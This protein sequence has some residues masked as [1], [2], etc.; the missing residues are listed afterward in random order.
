[1]NNV[2]SSNVLFPVNDNTSTAHVAPSSNHGYVARV[3]LDKVGD[4]ILFKVEL[5]CV[6]DTDQGIRITD[7]ATV[8]GDNVRNT[9]IAYSNAA[10]FEE[11]IF[12]FLGCDAVDG[13]S[14]LDIVKQ[15]EVF[16]GFFDRNNVYIMEKSSENGP[17]T[18]NVMRRTHE[19]SGVGWIC[20]NFVVD[21]DQALLDNGDDLSPS[22]S[23]L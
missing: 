11:L 15:T 7:R 2:I 21:F 1:M 5:H 13:E 3:E 16:T 10:N 6:V 8:V 17:K 9:T 19:A 4:F 23:I 14:P 20:A 22:Q 12:C 18:S